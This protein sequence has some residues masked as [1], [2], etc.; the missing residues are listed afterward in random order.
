MSAFA[1]RRP[2]R[3]CRHRNVVAACTA[4]LPEPYTTVVRARRGSRRRPGF[5]WRDLW[6]WWEGGDWEGGGMWLAPHLLFWLCNWERSADIFSLLYFLFHWLLNTCYFFSLQCF[7]AEWI[8]NKS[9]ACFFTSVRGSLVK[10]NWLKHTWDFTLSFHQF[11]TSSAWIINNVGTLIQRLWP[12]YWFRS[13]FQTC[14]Y[15][16]LF[17]GC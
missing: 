5:T 16:L 2:S 3:D 9:K 8:E 17:D 12:P 6:L 7:Y 14:L 13:R 15:V 11:V 4:S 1:A 10:E